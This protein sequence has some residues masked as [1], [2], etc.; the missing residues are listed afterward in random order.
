MVAGHLAA[1][2]SKQRPEVYR[3]PPSAMVPPPVSSHRRLLRSSVASSACALT[4]CCIKALIPELAEEAAMMAEPSLPAVVVGQL[5][6]SLAQH[7]LG[8]RP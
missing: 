5:L 3:V 1:R 8:A 4:G 2:H 7:C 6:P